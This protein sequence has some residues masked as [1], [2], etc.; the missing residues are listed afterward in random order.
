MLKVEKDEFQRHYLS[1]V[2]SHLFAVEVS[3]VESESCL[4]CSQSITETDPDSP[5]RLEVLELHLW[6]ER[7]E[8][9]LKTGLKRQRDRGGIV[10]GEG[11]EPG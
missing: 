7:T 8:Q 5:E 2:Q 4:G 9:G 3:L 6:V 11:S 1:E 10:E